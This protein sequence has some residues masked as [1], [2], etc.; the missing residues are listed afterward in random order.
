VRLALKEKNLSYESR[1]ISLFDQDHL[2][3]EYLAINPDG[4]V[5]TLVHDGDVITETAVINEYL[6][7]AFPNPPLRP[8]T[9]IGRARMRR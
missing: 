5:P 2:S 9:P 1:F 7:D 8:G 6:D 3:P 4:Q